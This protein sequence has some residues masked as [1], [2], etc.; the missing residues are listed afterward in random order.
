MAGS[1]LIPETPHQVLPSLAKNIGINEA[2][3]LQQLHWL[4]DNNDCYAYEGLLWWKHSNDQWLQKFPYFSE[5]TLKRTVSSLKKQ[6]L[7]LVQNL[8]WKIQKISG[9]R[10][11]WYAINFEEFEKISSEI[12]EAKRKKKF[13]QSKVNT[14]SA[15]PINT[16]SGQNDLTGKLSRATPGISAAAPENTGSGHIDL[17][18]KVNMTRCTSGHIDLML[19]KTYR[20]DLLSTSKPEPTQE[21]VSSEFDLV[22]AWILLILEKTYDMNLTDKAFAEAKLESYYSEGYKNPN[23]GDALS[24]VEQ[25]LNQRLQTDFRSTKISQARNSQADAVTR[26]LNAQAELLDRKTEDMEPRGTSNPLCRDWADT[27]EVLEVED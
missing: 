23:K 14:L 7:L 2:L 4:I 26:N 9:D 21:D 11:N 5:S 13:K 3:F 1:L 20:K 17:T 27:L 6:K 12:M 18:G 8:T 22:F 16:G 10:T 24:Y 15:A 19:Y 25:G